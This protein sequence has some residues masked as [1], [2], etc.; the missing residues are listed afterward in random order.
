SR[1]TSGKLAVRKQPVELG[2][3][4]Q[5]AVDTARPLL[6]DRKH[7]LTLELPSQPVYLQADPVRLAQVFSNLL[8]NAAKYTGPG[9][10]VKLAAAVQGTTVR[11]RIDDRGIGISAET[12]PRIFQ[13]FA[14]GDSSFERTHTGLGVGL[15]LAKRLIELHGG[16][17]GAESPGLGRGSS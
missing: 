11:V 12:L 3:V 9:G 13:M 2:T 10:E 5:N 1:I 15:A 6:D 17:I 8:N 16:S 7:T 4:V 14:Q